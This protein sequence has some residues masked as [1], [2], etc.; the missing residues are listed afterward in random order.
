[1]LAKTSATSVSVGASGDDTR[2][3]F[4]QNA[5]KTGWIP[6]VGAEDYELTGSFSGTFTLKSSEGEVTTFTAA[7][8][9]TTLW[10]ASTSYLEGLANTTTTTV[11]EAVTLGETKTSRRRPP[12]P[13][14]GPHRKRRGGHPRRAPVLPA[15]S[16]RR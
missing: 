7:G 12:L 4:T 9:S 6:E 14:C 1:M 5:A 8:G 3:N 16:R 2:L 15:G 10:N 11:S 13:S